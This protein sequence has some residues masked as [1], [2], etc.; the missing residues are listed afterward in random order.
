[1]CIQYPNSATKVEGKVTVDID[2]GCTWMRI[3]HFDVMYGNYTYMPDDNMHERVYTWQVAYAK[4]VKQEKINICRF[5][6]I[7]I[8]S[9]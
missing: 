5:Q 1:M 7:V 9:L 8:V 2:K 4:M 3:R 6:I